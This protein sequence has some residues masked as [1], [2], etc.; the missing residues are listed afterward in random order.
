MEGF[1]GQVEWSGKLDDYYILLKYG[2]AV[3]LGKNTSFGFGA[4]RVENL[5]GGFPHA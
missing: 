1:V 3:G 4:I 2:E 5:S